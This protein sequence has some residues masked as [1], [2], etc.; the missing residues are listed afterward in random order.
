M[1]GGS[2]QRV[3]CRSVSQIDGRAR[4]ITGWAMDGLMLVFLVVV[5]TGIERARGKKCSMTCPSSRCRVSDDGD[6]GGVPLWP[7]LKCHGGAGSI[8]SLNPELF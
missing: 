7:R 4:H 5:I 2:C 8:F 6:A 3:A 1:E